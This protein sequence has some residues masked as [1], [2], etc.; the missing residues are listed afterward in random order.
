MKKRKRYKLIQITVENN[1]KR[2]VSTGNRKEMN[3]GKSHD[4]KRIN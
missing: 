4:R 1:K 2:N 3:A